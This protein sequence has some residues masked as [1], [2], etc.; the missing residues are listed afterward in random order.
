MEEKYPKTEETAN[1]EF[2]QTGES[3]EKEGSQ[4]NSSDA[5]I[6]KLSE[7]LESQKDKYVRLMAE[8]ENYKRRNAK[9][10]MELIS[11]AGKEIIVSLLEVMDDMD[12]A[13]KQMDRSQDI[14]QIV[15]GNK[16]VFVK[17]RN[18]LQQKGLK[19][20]D[21]IGTEFDIEKHEAITK[22]EAGEAMRDK[23]VDELEKGYY[24][25][26]KIIRF[27]KVVVGN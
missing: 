21:S 1:P 15:E 6:A 10:R 24:L 5:G 18:I 20:M 9:E 17:L 19:A 4:E 7:E 27:A 26:E 13:E 2:D 8:F 3:T 14:A 23:V 25:N 22:L 12:R 11:T 16:L